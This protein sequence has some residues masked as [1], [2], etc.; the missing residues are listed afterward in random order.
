[1]QCHILRHKT[2]PNIY[3]WCVT[4]FSS[5]NLAIHDKCTQYFTLFCRRYREFADQLMI[6]KNDRLSEK[7]LVQTKFHQYIIIIIF[8][9]WEKFCHLQS[10]KRANDEDSF[11]SLLESIHLDR[12]HHMHSMCMSSNKNHMIR[13]IFFFALRADKSS[14]ERDDICI[15]YIFA[16]YQIRFRILSRAKY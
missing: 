8:G 7:H 14:S 4:N 13:T 3:S 16:P 2:Q 9:G 1:M 15:I 11:P 6:R 10:N 5:F 12:Q